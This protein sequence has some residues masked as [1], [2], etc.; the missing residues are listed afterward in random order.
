MPSITKRKTI[1]NKNTKKNTKKQKLN[2]TSKYFESI[3]YNNIEYNYIKSP[4]FKKASEPL[5]AVV[6]DLDETLGSFLAFKKL[7]QEYDKN[8]YDAFIKETSEFLTSPKMGAPAFRPG[9][10]TFLQT[11]YELKH[12]GKINS[13]IIYTN[14]TPSPFLKIDD[15]VYTRMQILSHIFDKIIDKSNQPLCDL[16]IFRSISYPPQKYINVIE[17]I[18]DND[19]KE[20]KFVFF[21]DKP[22]NILNTKNSTKPSNSAYGITEY[23]GRDTNRSFN[24]SYSSKGV[25]KQTVFD[26]LET[27]FE[28]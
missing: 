11:L 9:I 3:T 28:K 26:V 14:M 20:N 23:K 2:D 15:T 7:V 13:V 27:V 8:D 24:N 16:I 19:S 22:E 10:E 12:S 21:D 17:K 18:Y 4:S 6:L 5:R 25:E 1:N